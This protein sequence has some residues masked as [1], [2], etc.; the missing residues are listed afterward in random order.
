MDRVRMNPPA[1]HPDLIEPAGPTDP[2]IHFISVQSV[3]G[4]PIA[5]LANYSLH[6]VG[7]VPMGEV[8]ADY[9]AVFADRIGELLG[10]GRQHPPFVGI[11][12]NGTSGNIN[13]IDFKGPR[14]QVKPYEKMRTVANLIAAEVFK[15]YQKVEHKPWVRLAAASAELPLK[16]RVPEAKDIDWAES[17]LKK[18]K[19]A[20]VREV[21]YARRT[22]DMR[23]YPAE[24]AFPLQA[25]RI[26][27][28]AVASIPAEV[29]VEIGLEIRKRSD[30]AH[31]FTISLANGAY[32]YLPTPEQ[33][34]VGGYETW[35]GTN[36]VETGASPKIVNTLVD[37]I[38][39]VKAD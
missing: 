21:T 37:L 39:K 23:D 11:M 15:A 32:G 7:G 30:F 9:F 28:L 35:R 8:S 6:Y 13:N 24:I 38:R 18:A 19:P 4:R 26:G 10:A 33:Q 34:E 17:V 20:H 3:S 1:R 5:L 22:L 29:F 31:T 16:M 2:S 36:L 27:D 12:S 14:A 25:F